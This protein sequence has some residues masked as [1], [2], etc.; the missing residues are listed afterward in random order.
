MEYNFSDKVVLVTGASS[1]IGEATALL[2]AKFGA[3]LALVGR[4]E[5]NLNAVADQCMKELGVRVLPIIADLGTDEGCE[6]VAKMTLEHYGR[7]DVLVNNAGIGS[8]YDLIETNSMEMLDRVFSVNVRGVYNLTRLVVPA[9]VKSNGNIVNISSV[10]GKMVNVGM[11]TYSMSKV[12]PTGFSFFCAS[13]PSSG[14]RVHR[15]TTITSFYQRLTEITEEE[16]KK[17]LEDCERC[18]PLGKVCTSEDIAKTIVHVAS[19]HSC[20]VTGTDIV[21]DGGLQF[22]SFGNMLKDALN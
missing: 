14:A 16:Y 12:P 6:K 20:R 19:E 8:K 11:L 1:G 3:Q 22:S 13:C 15:T 21:V 9:L 17:H 4:N 18:I 10:V 7:L 2:F 5:K